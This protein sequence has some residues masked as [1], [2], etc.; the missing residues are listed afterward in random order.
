MIYASQLA[1]LNIHFSVMIEPA[2]KCKFPN[3]SDDCHGFFAI[4]VSKPPT[5]FTFTSSVRES[6]FDEQIAKM[7]ETNQNL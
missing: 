3:L 4:V 6:D 2:Q 1:A 7:L 5:I